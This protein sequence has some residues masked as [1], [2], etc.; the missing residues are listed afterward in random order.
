MNNQDVLKV[1]KWLETRKSNPVARELLLNI[2][3]NKIPYEI[4]IIIIQKN[5][6]P[7]VLNNILNK[8]L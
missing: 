7:K 5:I 1:K 3:D 6:N 8:K 4:K 2:N